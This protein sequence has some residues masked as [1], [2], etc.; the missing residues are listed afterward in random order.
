MKGTLIS[1]T[2]RSPNPGA[3]IRFY[4][5][6]DD[7]PAGQWNRLVDPDT[8]FLRHEFLAAMERNGCVGPSYG[9]LPRHLVLCDAGGQVLAAAPCYLKLNSYG[10]FVFDWAWADAYRRAALPYYPKLVIACP[11]TPATGPRIL[12]HPG[13]EHGRLSRM[14]IEG[15]I[16]AAQS[17]GVSSLHWLFTTEDETALTE[18]AGMLRRMGC[19]FHWQNQGYASWDDYLE[20]FRAEQR[21]KIRRERRRVREAGIR[22]RLLRG[23]EVSGK[24]WAVFHRLYRSTFEKRGGV[25]TLSLGFF[26]EIGQTLGESILVV[27]AYRDDDVVAGAFNLI[28]RNSLFG[29]HWG[30]TENYHSLHFETCYYQGLEFCIRE[31]LARFEPGAQGEHKVRRGFLPVSTWSGHWIADERFRTAIEGFLLAEGQGVRNYV[32]EMFKHSPFRRVP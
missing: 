23:A 24:E 25:P 18:Q 7:I 32:E 19:Q 9:W 12:A 21:K 26:R 30:C 2:T 29:R 17:L 4:E 8:P 5:S 1:E 31:G 27:L 20:E 11:Y 3:A 14:L 16:L 22:F 15:S 6:I 28:G 10:E 13:P